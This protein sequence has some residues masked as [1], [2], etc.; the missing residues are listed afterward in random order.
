[1][2]NIKEKLENFTRELYLKNKYKL[3]YLN[4][5]KNKCMGKIIG[6]ICEKIILYILMDHGLQAYADLSKLTEPS[7]KICAFHYI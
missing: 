1:M 2:Y 5:H 6:E 4:P 3:N 7:I